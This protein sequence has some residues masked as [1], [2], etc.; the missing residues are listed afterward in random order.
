MKVLFQN[1]YSDINLMMGVA[2]NTNG[3]QRNLCKFLH[4]KR[5]GRRLL[6]IPR[7]RWED[8]IKMD[9]RERGCH[10]TH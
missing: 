4:G 6:R 9:V 2:S 10:A 7:S 5:G 1:F 3:E 8:N